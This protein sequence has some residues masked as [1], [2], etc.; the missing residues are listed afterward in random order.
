MKIVLT[1]GSSTGK[2]SLSNELYR[3]KLVK[4]LLYIDIKEIIL[5]MGYNNIDDINGNI[6]LEFQKKY[7]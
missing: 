2:T 4:N 1:G 3:Q 6:F 7:L 5:E